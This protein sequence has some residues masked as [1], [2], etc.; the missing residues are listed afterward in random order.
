MT[1]LRDSCLCEPTAAAGAVVVSAPRVV[2][3][4]VGSTRSESAPLTS[5]VPILRFVDP[6]HGRLIA[7][8]ESI[9]AN[10]DYPTDVD[11]VII[12][13]TSGQTVTVAVDSM[14]FDAGLVAIG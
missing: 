2:V 10:L 13:L 1:C 12:E 6:D 8:G 11:Y 14:N 3:V 4:S 5:G 7:I 9:T